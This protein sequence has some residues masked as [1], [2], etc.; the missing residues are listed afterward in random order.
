MY[1]CGVPS[2]T[3][4]I[5]RALIE[6]VWVRGE[7]T[8]ALHAAWSS[9]RCPSTSSARGRSTTSTIP[10]SPGVCWQKPASPTALRPS[11]RFRLAYGR[12]LLDDAQLVQRFLKD[13]GI[14]AELKL[15]EYGAYVATTAQGKFEGLVRG[16][17]GIA[18]EPDSPLYRG[19]CLRLVVEQPAMS[20]IPT[21]TAMLKEQRRTKDLE[22][23]KKLIFDIQR[24]AAQQ[25]YYVYTHVVMVTASWQPYVKNY[26][27]NLSFD[28]GS[29]RPRC[30]W[31]GRGHGG[32]V[33]AGL[34]PARR[35]RG[36]R[37][38]MR[39]RLCSLVH[40]R[41][42]YLY[43]GGAGTG[44]FAR[45]T[46]TVAVATFGNERWLP[47]QYVAAEDIVLKPMLENL[48]SRDLKTGSMS[49]M[50]AERWEVLEGGRTWKFHLRK[51]IQFHDGWGEVTAEDV[52]FTL[53]AID[54]RSPELLLVVP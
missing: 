8:P 29:R 36:R 2:P 27:P 51:G 18:W 21:I 16:P 14:E 9:G 35:G 5:A 37:E 13:V 50:L 1:A 31:I 48:L 30:G 15:Q 52:K 39:Q 7:P 4:S 19:V 25:Q 3:P 11:S 33:G 54:S 17:C 12:D 10:R 26:A 34:L 42:A 6:A 41:G 28:Y 32:N 22:A 24:Y 44:S 20:M 23:R 46:L 40:R 38:R 45:R 53:A 49:A 43:F 47:H